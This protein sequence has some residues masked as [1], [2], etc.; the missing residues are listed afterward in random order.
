MNIP[1]N[2]DQ[3]VSHQAKQDE[4]L[5]KL[6]KCDFCGE[7]IQDEHCYQ[8]DGKTYCTDCLN[9]QFRKEIELDE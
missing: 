3:W 1:D 9:D 8:I 6:P 5:A 4:R 2:Y 7:P